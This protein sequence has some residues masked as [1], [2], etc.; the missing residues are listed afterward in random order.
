MGKRRKR[1]AGSFIRSMFEV[2]V[3]ILAVL[4]LTLIMSK[5]IVNRVTVRNHSMEQ[6][7]L[8][9]DSVLIDK[10]SYRFRDPQR[11][12]IIVFD[13]KGTGEDL[14]KRIIGLPGE[15]VQIEDGKIL[16]DGEE[17]KDIKNLDPPE[18]AGLAS[19]PINLS[20]GEYFV[21][22]DNRQESIDSRYE[23]VGI[24]TSTRITGKMFMRILPLKR[25]RFF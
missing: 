17:L 9:N 25:I 2:G 11:F 5:Y 19:S 1:K 13:Q 14:I 24:V 8:E 6:T 10:I 21:L 4:L 16:I 15:T 20:V 18:N 23:Q 12:D 22:G 7:L 3:F